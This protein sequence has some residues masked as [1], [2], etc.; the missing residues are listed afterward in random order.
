MTDKLSDYK[1]AENPLPD[2]YLLWPLYGAGFD[3]MGLEGKPIEVNNQAC[4]PDELI[5]RHDAVGL[6]FSDIKIINLGQNHP[7]IHH[8]MK[9]NPVVLGHEVAMTVVAVGENMTDRYKPGDRLTIEADIYVDGISLAYGYTFQGGLSQYAVID[10]LVMNND[11]GDALIPVEPASGYAESALTEPWACVIAA[12]RLEYRT[13]IRPGG[14]LWI[15][16][17]GS[18]RPFTISAGFDQSC[19]P[20]RLL[21][22]EVPAGLD[23]W[24]RKEAQA[25]GIEVF[26][27]PDA[28]QPPFDT[29]DDIILL[30]ADPDRVEQVSQFLAPYGVFA[31]AAEEK[32]PRKTAVDVGRIHYSRWVYVGTTSTD[33]AAAY[34]EVPVRSKLK[35]GGKA[36]FVGA[37]GPIGRMHVQ[38]AISFEDGP[39]TIVCTDVSDARLD[40]LCNSFAD[41]A[42]AKGI[43]WVCLNP[44][45]K[46]NYAAVMAPY[47]ETGFD[48]II[49]L[50]P[51]PPVISDAAQH[52]AQN[53][54]INVFAGV[55]KGTTAELDLTD[56]YQKQVRMIGHSGSNMIDMHITL[57]KSGTNELSRNRS[58]AAIGSLSAAREGLMAVKNTV[59]PGKVVIY[60]NIKEL[61]LTAIGDLKHTLP[62]VYTRLKD[63]R[64]WTN[65]A[66]EELLRL[67]LP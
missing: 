57:E 14:T 12:Y 1:K 10:R 30:G 26:D 40:D 9:T 45:D 46:E 11:H 48:D 23:A 8:D 67:M 47:F 64:E 41:E 33:L 16:G 20:A 39:S 2:R 7:R 32:M 61:P 38:A 28:S 51:V 25:L 35:P 53:S 34:H 19:H 36:W 63:G 42:R 59:Y 50:V 17:A 37:G 22:T 5:V 4:G 13:T 55:N 27:V 49:V 31:I 24:L 54:V 66:E 58:V 44:N 56:V 43:E 6:C 62:T 60:P 3:S 52:A 65:E 21:L 29:V 18:D 15:I